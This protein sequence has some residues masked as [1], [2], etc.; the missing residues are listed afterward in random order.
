M[1]RI[2]KMSMYQNTEMDCSA[3][4]TAASNGMS[5]AGQRQPYTVVTLML[6][7]LTTMTSVGIAVM[8]GLQRAVVLPEQ[9]AYVALAVT[10][11]VGAHLLPA[12]SR[13]KSISV[14]CWAAGLCVA[15]MLVTLYGQVTFFLTTQQRAG[16]HRAATAAFPP[17]GPQTDTASTRDLMAIASDE[18]KIRTMLAVNDSRRCVGNCTVLRMRHDLLEAKL[19]MLATEEEEAKRHEA[20]VDHRAELAERLRDSMREDP[21]TA[22]LAR[23][24]GADEQTLNL[25]LAIVCAG[26]LDFTGSFGWFLVLE[27][28]R[29][30]AVVKV[31]PVAST[32]DSSR[33]E[34]AEADERPTSDSST[35]VTDESDGRLIQL[36][37]DV[38]A[39]KV[40]PTI[41]GIR[42]HFNCAQKAATELR[43]QYHAVHQAVH[44]TAPQS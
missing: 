37:H 42:V 3:D 26:V 19:R 20:D 14:R 33:R 7:L 27:R 34:Q 30:N 4:A 24:T 29:N 38:A 21:A 9:V 32:I 23:A 22:R 18:E 36:V 2:F 15:S 6:A 12:L 43:R 41:E 31:S 35:P 39:G 1:K 5:S 13:G 11:V 8:S 44:S 17:V 25:L 28:G 40:R 10:A 16:N